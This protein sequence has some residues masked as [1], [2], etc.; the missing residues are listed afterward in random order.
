MYKEVEGMHGEDATCTTR[1]IRRGPVRLQDDD[2]VNDVELGLT[3]TTERRKAKRHELK[4]AKSW[5]DSRWQKGLPPWVAPESFDRGSLR[6]HEVSAATTEAHVLKSS[7]TMREWADEYCRSDKW[8]KEFTYE[9]VCSHDV[10]VLSIY[11]SRKFCRSCMAGT[12]V[13]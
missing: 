10:I 7:Q 5:K 1:T 2:D 12:S 3:Q 11:N 6:P 8:L 9:K 13:R 4:S